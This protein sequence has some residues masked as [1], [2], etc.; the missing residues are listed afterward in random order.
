MNVFSCHGKSTVHSVEMDRDGD[1][2]LICFFFFHFVNLSGLPRQLVKS[3]QHAET[4]IIFQGTARVLLSRS[5]LFFRPNYY[6]IDLS[7]FHRRS[8]TRPTVVTTRTFAFSSEA[9]NRTGFY[10]VAATRR[11]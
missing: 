8:R 7:I 10:A 5:T 6:Y 2:D 11:L 4:K 3:E 1:L 9:Y